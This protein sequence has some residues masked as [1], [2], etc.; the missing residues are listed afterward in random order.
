MTLNIVCLGEAMAEISSDQSGFRVG[1]AGD[2]L[3]T[4]IYLQRA[5]GGAGQVQYLTRVGQDPLSEGLID[6][7]AD[8]GIGTEGI[9]CDPERQVGIYS[10]AVDDAGERSFHYWRNQSA[11]RQMFTSDA[12][13]AAM[14][15]A[16]VIYL[17][18]ISIAILSPEGRD[19]LLAT[20]DRLRAAGRRVAFDSNYRPRLWEDAATAR[21]TMSA[22]WARADIA[23][24]S[25]DDEQALFGDASDAAVIARLADT[26]VGTGAL[27]RGA[28]GPLPIGAAM[29]GATYLR[30]ERIVDSTAAGDSFNGA[31]LA[32]YLISG[33]LGLAMLR[34]HDMARRVVGVRGAILPRD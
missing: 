4:A 1:F 33:D 14:D 3:N 21:A 26:G 10:I 30:A 8:E 23:L 18:G 12:E 31:F 2:T 13:Q 11:A 27:K 6:F 28:D 19:R 9:T 15:A 7:A 25:V 5:L 32:E 22:F 29:P 20:L 16:D 24:P 17:S 34:G